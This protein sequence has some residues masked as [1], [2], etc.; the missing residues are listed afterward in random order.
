M[1]VEQNGVS[2][3]WLVVFH[4][5]HVFE[6]NERQRNPGL[7]EDSMELCSM[8]GLLGVRPKSYIG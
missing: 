7:R 6:R 4:I 1:D 5:R 8:E 2:S 3:P